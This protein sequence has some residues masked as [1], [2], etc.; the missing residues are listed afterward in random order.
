MEEKNT[1]EKE[2]VVKKKNNW[3]FTLF[4][5]VMTAIIVALAMNLGQKAS[6]IVDPDTSTSKTEEKKEESSNTQTE[7][8]VQSNSNVVVEEKDIT[9][10]ETK[11]SFS[12][13]ISILEDNIMYKFKDVQA[14]S[15]YYTKNSLNA[16]QI[17]DSSKFFTIVMSENRK[18]TDSDEIEWSYDAQPILNQVRSLYGEDVQLYKGDISACPHTEYNSST[19]KYDVMAACGYTLMPY[20][21]SYIYKITEKEDNVYVYVSTVKFD[22]N[23]TPGSSTVTKSVYFDPEETKEYKVIKDVEEFNLDETNYDSF[24]KFKYTFA[25]NT[26]GTYKFVSIERI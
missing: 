11:A 15:L 20:I 25:K 10:A 7:S 24:T 13:Y 9:S 5:C 4:A 3:L 16:S 14:F 21:K 1:E 23:A 22:Y 18:R 19:N 17:P 6:K 8:N 2:V 26:D 12:K